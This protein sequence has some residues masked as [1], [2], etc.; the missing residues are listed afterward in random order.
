MLG[1]WQV[2]KELGPQATFMAN[3]PEFDLICKIIKNRKGPKLS[4]W[5]LD[6]DPRTLRIGTEAERYESEEK[7]RF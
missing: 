4:M 5:R 2:K 7:G 3:D 6:L 1:L